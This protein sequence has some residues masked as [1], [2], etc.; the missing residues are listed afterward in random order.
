MSFYSK[1]QRKKLIFL[2]TPEIAAQ[3]L[4]YIY[5]STQA[6]LQ[7]VAVVSQPPV[8]STRRGTERPSPVHSLAIE[9]GI[10]VLTPAS[11][12]D[13]SFLNTLKE[14][15][16]DLFLTVSYGQFLP[17][18]F[19]DIPQYGTLNIHPSLLPKYR[20][21]SPVQ[22]AIENGESKTGV[23]LLFSTLAMDAGPIFIQDSLPL[24]PQI[25]SSKLLENLMMHGAKLFVKNYRKVFNSNIHLVEQEHLQATQA[26]KLTKEEGVLDFL[27]NAK[28]CHDKVRA[29]D[30]WP[31]TTA[32]FLIDDMLKEIRIIT[33]EY[34]NESCLRSPKDIFIN[35]ENQS[36]DICCG[37]SKIL[38]IKELQ[39]PSKRI[40]SAG[41][42]INGLHDRRIIC[43]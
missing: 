5:K 14:L 38:H 36:I 43:I 30:I 2:G 23:T 39:E 9:L 31:K 6:S 42:Y 11:A 7:V 12:K 37:D 20:G 3:V 29:F 13:D 10:P 33:T 24:D 8:R 16:P 1:P 41:D 34:H 27:Q 35:K 26:K 15:Q 40:V 22:R 18:K 25:K 19:L 32:K 28:T 4:R 21:A 17:K